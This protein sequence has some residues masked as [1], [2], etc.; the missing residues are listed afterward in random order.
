MAISSFG[1]TLKWGATADAVKKVVDIKDFPDL[2]GD[3]NLLE[4]TTLSDAQQT[5][6]PG[7]KSSDTLSFTANYT[8]VDFAAVKAD[9]NKSLFYELAFSDG[10]KFTWS[11]Q[12]TCG[13]P[14]K[15]VD[16]VVEFT[17]N[18]AA[19]TAVEF[20]AAPIDEGEEEP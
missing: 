20:V 12:H 1:I 13:M 9:E 7:I 3:P 10:S 14:G 5:N 4:T 16:E 11:G 19:A 18:I 6:I 2:I 17:I 8:S 15:G